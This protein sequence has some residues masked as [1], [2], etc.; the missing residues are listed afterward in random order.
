MENL[1]FNELPQ[2]I[3]QLY[4]KLE[5]IERLLLNQHKQSDNQ[6]GQLLT[7]QQ[8]ADL[9]NLSVPTI[10]GLVSRMEIPVSKKGKRL[11]FSKEE[12]ADWVK[13]GRR[14]TIAEIGATTLIRKNGNG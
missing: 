10:Y 14:R 3:T 11:Y 4:E 1:T 7:V 13:T 12:L 6:S 2:A 5:Q 8:A 9:L